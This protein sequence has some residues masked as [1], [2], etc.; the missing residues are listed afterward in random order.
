MN[1]PEQL[2]PLTGN[3]D[4]LATIRAPIGWPRDAT[5]ARQSADWLE[6]DKPLPTVGLPC[7]QTGGDGDGR[8]GTVLGQDCH[9]DWL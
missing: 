3:S 9:T 2:P 7:G 1:Q 6:H 5:A 8:E 4:T